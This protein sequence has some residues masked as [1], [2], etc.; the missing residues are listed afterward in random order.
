MSKKQFVLVPGYVR[1]I[2][3]GDIHYITAQKLA[4]L[5]HVQMHECYVYPFDEAHQSGLQRQ[6]LDKNCAHLKWLYP[7]T[8]GDYKPVE[9]DAKVS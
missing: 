4:G 3:D 6:W 2:N 9:R 5:Y 8:R 1:S 7:R